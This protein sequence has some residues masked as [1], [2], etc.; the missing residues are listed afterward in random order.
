[1]NRPTQYTLDVTVNNSTDGEQKVFDHPRMDFE[2]LITMLDGYVIGD[3]SESSWV[4]TV[5]KHVPKDWVVIG[6]PDHEAEVFGPF[7]DRDHAITWAKL[8]FPSDT[9]WVVRA[10]DKAIVDRPK[11]MSV[12]GDVKDYVE[13]SKEHFDRYIAGD[14]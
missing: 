13:Q 5:V 8:E 7:P 11:P 6:D 14:R 9:D 3:G 4:F 1:M 10:I 2:E 12:E